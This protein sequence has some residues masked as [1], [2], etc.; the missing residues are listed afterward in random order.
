MA[1]PSDS[2]TVQDSLAS[3]W[4]RARQT[5]S[6]IK[7]ITIDIRDQSALDN[8][9][10]ARLIALSRELADAKVIFQK[11]AAVSGISAYAQDQIADPSLNVTTAF[12]AMVTELTNTIAW[13]TANFPKDAS[14]YLLYM[15]FDVNGYVVNRTFTPAQTTGLRTVLNALIATID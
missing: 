2:G 6:T 1:F 14:G 13:I 15:Q 3:A 12:N 10:A 4:L 7:S 8:I 9:V 11:C 5:A